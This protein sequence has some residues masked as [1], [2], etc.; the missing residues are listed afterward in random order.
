MR[1]NR[2]RRVSGLLV[3]APLLAALQTTASPAAAS[4]AGRGTEL[5][6]TDLGTLPGGQFSIAEG[7]NDDAE[8]AG[9]S[10]VSPGIVHAFLW[11]EGEM[12][13]LGTL[14]GENSQATDLNN[15]GEVVG[16]SNPAGGFEFHA[17]LWRDGEMTDLGTLG[18][19]ASTAA[20]ASPRWPGGS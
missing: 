20:G 16:S 13:D 4:A 8:V 3:L 12:L 1:R 7:I 6:L 5:Q 15:R 9:T 19:T 14:G 11:R 17:F 2:Y 18:G 10:D